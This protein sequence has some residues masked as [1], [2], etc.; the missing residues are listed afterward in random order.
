VALR[1]YL[2]LIP[3]M[4]IVSAVGR[5]R[6]GMAHALAQALFEAGCNLEDTTMTRLSGEFAMILIV[7]PPQ[8]LE[9]SD[10]ENSLRELEATHGLFIALRDIS[11]EQH[12]D[13]PSS[14][15]YIVT[16]Y[17]PDD[18]GLLARMTGVLARHGANITD[19]QSRVS[20]EA[21]VMIFQIE[22]PLD[23]KAGVLQHALD[24]AAHAIGVTVSLRPLEEEVI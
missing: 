2:W 10:L 9:L 11:D 22:A 1:V 3:L 13:E 21:Y 7:T 24:E 20:G 19:V 6:P 16:C 14:S 23:L 8:G 15:P 4:F 18:E 17:G 5:D 12:E